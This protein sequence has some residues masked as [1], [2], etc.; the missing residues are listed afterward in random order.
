MVC[1]RFEAAIA[2]A[3]ELIVLLLDT[4]V[5]VFWVTDSPQLRPRTRELMEKASDSLL[6]SAISVWEIAK[7]VELGRLEFSVGV[8]EWVGQALAY[9]RVEIVPLSPAIAIESTRLPEPFHKDPADQII[10]AAARV[11]EC[12][13]VTY[14]GKIL[15]YKSV[16]LAT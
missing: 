10:V 16:P 2:Q 1:G 14:D 7:L 5:F 12:P 11:L 9:P 13:L 6:L 4:H 8:D 15:A 3:F